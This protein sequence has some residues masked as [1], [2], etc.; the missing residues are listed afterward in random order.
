MAATGA[1]KTE[2]NMELRRNIFSSNAAAASTATAKEGEEQHPDKKQ[3]FNCFTCGT[4]CTKLRFHSVKTKNFELCSNCYLEGR[5]PSTM[6]SGDFIRLNAQHFKH[7]TDDTWTDQETLLL[8]EGLEMHE[9][10]WNL[11][12]EHVGTRSREQCILHFLQLPI[13]DPYLGVASERELGPLQYHR[14]PFSQ[15]DNPVMSVVA[16]LASVVNPGVAAAAAKSALKELAQAKK[17]VESEST[18]EAQTEEADKHAPVENGDAEPKAEGQSGKMD[19]DKSAGE[20][21]EMK[22]DG[23]VS[24]DIAGLPRSTLEKV[25]AAALGSAAA[26]AKVLADNEEREVRRLVTQVVEAQLKKMELKLQQ[27][28]EL[29]SVLET[30]KRELERQRQQLY[31]DRLA[32]KKSIMSMQEKFQLARQTSNPQVIANVTVPPGGVTG[33]GTTF[34]NEATVR[35]QQEQGQGVVPL[36]R[37]QNAEGVVVMPLP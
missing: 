18:E 11:V 28:E 31:L 14:I 24:T 36:T 1:P 29:E 35:Q 19:V 3:R 37:D 33:A 10:D 7:A 17:A 25:G 21:T 2:A 5:F 20:D 27:F 34:Q 30:E 12:A 4:D 9:D 22:Q 13:E 16:F 32:M 26:K 15:A 23:E 6:S 8:L